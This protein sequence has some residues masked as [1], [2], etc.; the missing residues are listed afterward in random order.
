MTTLD[1]RGYACPEPVIRLKRVIGSH[2]EIE[3]RVD[4]QASAD[5]CRRFA[6][7]KG[8]AVSVRRDGNDHVLEVSK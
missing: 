3:L 6:E 1:V 8:F 4:N 7:S 2:N 5:V